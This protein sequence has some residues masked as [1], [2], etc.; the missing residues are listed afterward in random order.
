MHVFY[1]A[2][3]LYSVFHLH[4][5]ESRYWLSSAEFIRSVPFIDDNGWTEAFSEFPLVTFSIMQEP[6]KLGYHNNVL[7]EQNNWN[8]RTEKKII[9]IWLDYVSLNLQ[10]VSQYRYSII[11][12]IKLMGT[13][14]TKI[15]KIF[16]CWYTYGVCH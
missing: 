11:K 6:P 16:Y 15:M 5:V 8:N 13:L 1:M 12:H 14:K 3:Q 4:K 7:Y 9:I 10:I 2:Q